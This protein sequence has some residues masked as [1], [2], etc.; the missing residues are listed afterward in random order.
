MVKGA[1]GSGFKNALALTWVFVSLGLL[2][3]FLIA[4][5][6]LTMGSRGGVYYLVQFVAVSLLL[7][8]LLAAYCGVRVS[9]TLPVQGRGAIIIILLKNFHRFILASFAITGFAF[10]VIALTITLS[11]LG[12]VPK[13]GQLLV[14]LTT[15]PV[16]A[17][18]F[19]GI[20][21]ALCLF[22][23]APALVMD[24]RPGIASLTRARDLI[25]DHWLVMT[26]YLL[27][28]LSLL[29]LVTVGIFYIAG[30][31]AGISRAVQWNIGGQ[32][33]RIVDALAMKSFFSD[34]AT[35]IAPAVEKMG[36]AAAYNLGP[37]TYGQLVTYILAGSYMTLGSILLALPLAV[38]FWVTSHFIDRVAIRSE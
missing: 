18:N 36:L 20:L 1:K 6:G 14:S 37:M 9:S 21:L 3:Y 27:V 7:T 38:Y 31:A 15:I 30:H 8:C 2:F 28:S 33:P 5:L 23:I 12:L 17:L 26:I 24:I 16:F 4:A 25:R 11:L 29:A 10:H 34:I 32:Y 13:V 22:I 35:S 19:T